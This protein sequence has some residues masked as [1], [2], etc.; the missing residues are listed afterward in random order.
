MIAVV[1][2]VCIVMSI[3]APSYL[4]KLP[5]DFADSAVTYAAPL[6]AVVAASAFAW[7]FAL[8]Q[9]PRVVASRLVF[10][11]GRPTLMPVVLVE[12]FVGRLID[13][14]PATVILIP[15]IVDMTAPASIRPL[16]MGITVVTA[17]TCGLVTGLYG[18][19]LLMATSFAGVPFV[20]GLKEAVPTH[21]IFFFFLR[22]LIV[23][24]K[25]FLTQYFPPKLNF[26][27]CL[28]TRAAER[29]QRWQ[30]QRT[31]RSETAYRSGRRWARAM[32]ISSPV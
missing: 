22:Q 26:G 23:L 13:P 16:H 12:V 14:L 6:L 11:A 3:L 1:Y 7:M 4:K 27:D 32:S 30:F 2:G 28:A 5:R 24:K 18:L 29:R 17:L 25:V 31:L 20:K 10:A 8:L 9:A 21:S 15:L 19:S